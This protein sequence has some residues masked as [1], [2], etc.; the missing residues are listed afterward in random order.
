MVLSKAQVDRLGERLRRG[1][2]SDED[3]QLLDTYRTSFA[4]PYAFVFGI[5]RDQL[6]LAPTGREKTTKSIIDKLR[7]ESVRLSQ[8]QDVAGCRVVVPSIMLQ[9]QTVQ[10]LGSRFSDAV[11][12]D[13][14]VRPSHGYRAVHLILP[15]RD[16]QV[17]VQV[18]T[19]LQQRWA[20]LSEKLS[21][22]L[23]IAVKY[24]GGSLAVQKLLAQ[25]SE[26]S[27]EVER[28]EEAVARLDWR[29]IEAAVS[30][31]ELP[32]FRYLRTV[33]LAAGERARSDLDSVLEQ[34]AAEFLSTPEAPN[35]LPD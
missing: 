21:D 34:A 18:R 27:Q 24:G 33:I 25:T 28:L 20:E 29:A 4:D 11:V 10:A 12:V 23:G 15:V 16:R 14:R 6:A 35:A 2:V 30:Q 1:D 22:A 31:S 13:R 9:D 19:T 17:E 5:L 8:I 32:Y 26:I 3:I 7:R